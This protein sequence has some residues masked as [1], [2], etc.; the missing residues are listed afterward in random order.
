MCT[1]KLDKL[2]HLQ[3]VFGVQKLF[4]VR[5]WE[6]VALSSARAAVVGAVVVIGIPLTRWHCRHWGKTAHLVWSFR[7]LR[8]IWQHPSEIL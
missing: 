2:S 6:L 3:P 8:D 4:R 1:Y 7:A 5:L